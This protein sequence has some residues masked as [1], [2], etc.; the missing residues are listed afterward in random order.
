MQGALQRF[1]SL[2]ALRAIRHRDFRLLWSG[3]VVSFTGS[4]IQGLAQGYLVYELTGDKALLAFVMFA[5]MIPV[6]VLGPVF[7]VFADVMDRRKV[8][9]ASMLVFASAS[10]FLGFA[11]HFGFIQYWHIIVAAVINGLMMTIE[12]PARQA[13]VREVVPAEDLSAAIPSMGMTFNLARV[14]GPAV[15]GLLVHYFGTES[16]FWINA[17]SY[18][19]LIVAA[20]AIKSDLSARQRSPQPVRDLLAEGMLYTL[21]EKTLR[22][23]F[24]LECVTSVFGVWYMALM[25]AIA[26]D[27]LGLDEKGLGVGMSCIGV[28]AIT[29]LVTLASLSQR[30]L[31]ALLVRVAMSVF[32]AALFSLSFVSVPWVAFILFGCLGAAMMT[33]FNTTNTLFQL[34]SP[35]HLRGRVLSMHMWAITGAAPVGILFFGWISRQT[36][37]QVAFWIGGGIVGAGAVAGW[38]LRG[39]VVEPA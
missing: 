4:Q 5:N 32:A 14:V 3:A 10:A 37:L 24:Y 2:P 21:R 7:G 34:I 27:V 20:L 19:G 13:I 15:G 33:Q 26:K 8:L 36:S 35:D 1:K 12:T 38:M 30:R 16:C 31:K 23:L 29:A 6:S 9:V 39:R 25:P 11:A 22:V 28:G 17:A 18:G